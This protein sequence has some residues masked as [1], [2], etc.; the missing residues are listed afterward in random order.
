MDLDVAFSA[1]ILLVFHDCFLISCCCCC[2]SSNFFISCNTN[3]LVTVSTSSA[4]SPF[5]IFCI[6]LPTLA[7]TTISVYSNY[8][9]F[10]STFGTSQ[11][12]PVQRSTTRK[13]WLYRSLALPWFILCHAQIVV[14][15]KQYGKY[16][17]GLSLNKCI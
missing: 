1:L 11:A 7:S 13:T 4:S 3:Q 6:A 15:L 8:F 2:C 14:K 9:V 5:S 17:R 10:F 16:R 12:T